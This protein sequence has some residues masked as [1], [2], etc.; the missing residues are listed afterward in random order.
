MN[1][2]HVPTDLELNALVTY[3]DSFRFIL[4]QD[5]LNEYNKGFVN[6]HKQPTIE[7]SVVYEGAVTLY[8]LEQEQIVTAGNGF[9][10]MP[11]YLHSICPA[12]G[13]AAAKYYTLIFHPEILYGKPGSY[14]DKA[15]YH[16]LS[17]CNTPF[18]VFSNHEKWTQEVFSQLKW[19]RDQLPNISPEFRLKTQHILQNIWVLFASNLT[20][21]IQSCSAVRDTRKILNLVTYLHEHYQKKF[22]LDAIAKYVSMS[23]SECCRY[24]KTM[25]NM[26]ITEYLLEYRL[27]KA[28]TLLENSNLS[29]TEISEQTG[30]CDVSYFIKKFRTKTG[31]TPKAYVAR[32]TQEMQ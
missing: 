6:W 3:D 14:Y 17:D 26:T 9:F 22:S 31:I 13:Y 20:N 29:I 19:I 28:V 4:S 2:R 12:P 8:V 25:M 10:I 16:P 1:K 5:D 18:F 21:Q 24:F 15:Y 30:F 27:S 11:G 7:I 32:L 23:R